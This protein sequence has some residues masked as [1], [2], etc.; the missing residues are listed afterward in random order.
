MLDNHV[1]HE[2]TKFSFVKTPSKFIIAKLSIRKFGSSS[3]LV[4]MT[5]CQAGFATVL[6]LF[7]S[8]QKALGTGL[9]HPLFITNIYALAI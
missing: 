6:G 3:V 2:K 1:K 8:L 9:P 5:K 4:C 7:S